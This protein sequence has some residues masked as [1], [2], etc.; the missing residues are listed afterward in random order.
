[1]IWLGIALAVFV[2]LVAWM[3]G[4]TLKFARLQVEHHERSHLEREALKALFKRLFK[5]AK[6]AGDV[7]AARSV[8]LQALSMGIDV[9][10][11]S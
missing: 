10:E 8:Q 5:E 7:G 3:V 4:V 1:M 9:E 2:G 11:A 6:A